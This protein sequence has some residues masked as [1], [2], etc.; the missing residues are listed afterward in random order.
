MEILQGGNVSRHNKRILSGI[1]FNYVVSTKNLIV[2]S[3]KLKIKLQKWIIRKFR[4]ES[5]AF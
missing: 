4:L 3:V 1:L 5:Q 2:V